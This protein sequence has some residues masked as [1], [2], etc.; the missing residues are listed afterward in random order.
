MSP[1]AQ[2]SEHYLEGPDIV[3]NSCQPCLV[4]TAIGDSLHAKESLSAAAVTYGKTL[5]QL[6][7]HLAKAAISN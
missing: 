3:A 5:Q 7:S 4:I 6:P 2:I 1:T